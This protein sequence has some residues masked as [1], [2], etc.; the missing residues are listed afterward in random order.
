MRLFFLLIT[1]SAVALAA[2]V[3][4]ARQVSIA[5]IINVSLLL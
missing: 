3:L 1:L 4:E 5:V 2:P